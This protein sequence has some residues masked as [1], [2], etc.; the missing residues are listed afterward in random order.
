MTV[1]HRQE[2]CELFHTHSVLFEDQMGCWAPGIPHPDAEPHRCLL[3]GKL[4]FH[5]EMYLHRL[6]EYQSHALNIRASP[7]DA[8]FTAALNHREWVIPGGFVLLANQSQSW[9]SGV[10]SPLLCGRRI[11]CVCVCLCVKGGSC[12]W[13]CTLFNCIHWKIN[14]NYYVFPPLRELPR[15]SSV[16]HIQYVQWRDINQTDT[17]RQGS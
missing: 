8:L 1:S 13:G 10:A 11:G 3:Q 9:T 12:Q 16:P 2:K 7:S 5:R 17:R 14:C 6:R 4:L 15:G